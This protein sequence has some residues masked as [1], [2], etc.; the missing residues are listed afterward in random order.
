MFKIILILLLAFNVSCG[1]RQEYGGWVK[2]NT[3]EQILEERALI[4]TKKTEVCKIEGVWFDYYTGELLEDVNNIEIDHILPVDFHDKY[5]RE[6]LP[7]N[8]T[9]DDRDAEK[10]K[11]KIFYNDKDNLVIT[12]KKNNGKKSNK[13]KEEYVKMIEDEEI[14]KIYI[15]QYDI[16]YNKYCK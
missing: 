16:I 9:A 4:I 3:R 12:S 13:T 6:K 7:D 10:R 8:A 2:C 1:A 5:C 15:T 11:L 14:A